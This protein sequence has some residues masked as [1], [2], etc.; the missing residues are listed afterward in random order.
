LNWDP[1]KRKFVPI[2]QETENGIEIIPD[3]KLVIED[4][5]RSFMEEVI[6]EDNYRDRAKYADLSG[7]SKT[8]EL[9]RHIA[10]E[11]DTHGIEFRERIYALGGIVEFVSDT[12]EY[13]AET[14]TRSEY[15]DKMDQAFQE[16]IQRARSV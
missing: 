1:V 14:I 5:N 15:T 3:K 11:E 13:M 8:A 2:T 4:L 16:A 6:A 10:K 7:D 9:Y 12:A